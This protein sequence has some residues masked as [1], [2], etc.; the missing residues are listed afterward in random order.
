MRYWILGLA[1]AVVFAACAAPRASAQ[2]RS[3]GSD[4][5]FD[6]TLSVSGP[7]DLDVATGSGRIEIR[8][9]ASNRIEVHGTIWVGRDRWF[10]S[11]RDRDDVVRRLE[12]NPPIE[13]TGSNRIRITASRG[14]TTGAMCRSAMKS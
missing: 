8:Q 10:R 3:E 12:E 2:R 14:A 11:D 13:Q 7:V 1:A 6:R 9:G 4:G 5:S